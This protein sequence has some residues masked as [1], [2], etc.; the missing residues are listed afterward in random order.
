M[1]VKIKDIKQFKAST[2][3]AMAKN[4][5][6]HTALKKYIK[7]IRKEEKKKNE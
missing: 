1:K 4:G 2:L 6:G 5:I 7:D 3:N